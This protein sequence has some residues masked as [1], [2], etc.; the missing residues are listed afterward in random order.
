MV[1][2]L[3]R[4]IFMF[5][6]R[7]KE[8]KKFMKRESYIEI[9]SQITSWLVARNITKTVFSSSILVSQNASRT[10]RVNTFPLEKAKTWLELLDMLVSTHISVTSSQEEMI[11]KQLD[12]SFCTFWEEVYLGKDCLAEVKMKNITILKRRS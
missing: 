4:K 9:L 1:N 10:Q 5:N 6:Y 2:N 11:L 12:M 8:F 3:Y 7:F